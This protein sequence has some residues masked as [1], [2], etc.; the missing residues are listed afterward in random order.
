MQAN[1]P[2]NP[3]ARC[4]RIPV[5]RNVWQVGGYKNVPRLCL[6]C[7]EELPP[8]TGALP[9]GQGSMTGSVRG[10]SAGSFKLA[11]VLVW[12]LFLEPLPPEVVYC[13]FAYI[14]AKHLSSVLWLGLNVELAHGVFFTGTTWEKPKNDAARASGRALLMRRLLPVGPS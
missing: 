1:N 14:R 12:V 11:L 5:H 10:V 2:I 4:A 9:L 6:L 3:L 13:L 7:S 8:L